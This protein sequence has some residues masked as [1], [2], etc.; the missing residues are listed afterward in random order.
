MAV[1]PVR[2]R[3]PLLPRGGDPSPG[4]ARCKARAGSGAGS[5]HEERAAEVLTANLQEAIISSENRMEATR[6]NLPTEKKTNDPTPENNTPE[7]RK[8]WA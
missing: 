4:R 7:P 3:R 2:K 5:P 1:E 6:R 8:P